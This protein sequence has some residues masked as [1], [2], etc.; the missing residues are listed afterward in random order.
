MTWIRS[1][2]GHSLTSGGVPPAWVPT[3]GTFANVGS[4]TLASV[5]PTGWPTSE[6]AGPY[7]NWSSGA[8][9]QDFG[10]IGGYVVHGS[11]HLTVGTPI[12][13]GVWVWDAS[14]TTW[15]GRNVPAAPLLEP[16]GTTGYDA[17]FASTDSTTL[18]H[19]YAPHTYDGLIYQSAANGGGAAGSLIRNFFAGSPNTNPRA[20]HKF[21]LSSAA[22]APSRVLDDVTMAGSSSSYPASALDEARGGYWL[23]TYNGQGPLKF[24]RFAD[25]SVTSYTGVEYSDYGD[26]HLIYLPAPYDAIVAIGRTDA[27]AIAQSLRVSQI[28]GGTPGTFVSI[29]PAGTAPAAAGSGKAGG[30]WSSLLSCIVQYTGDGSYTV[31][32]LTPPAP[33]SLTSG[34]WTWS[35]ETLTGVSGATPA[36]RGSDSSGSYSRFIEV[37]AFRCFLWSDGINNVMQAWR[38]T[39][40]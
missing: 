22:G 30:C 9:A 19:T 29:T 14:I 5:S 13:A 12:W 16:S 20:V 21:D 10:T 32:K 27:G 25:W 33:G 35:S 39:G 37:S 24:V 8:W 11:G 7:A 26:Q 6:D 18:G 4:S 23:L 28:T 15:V 31:F 1:S 3:A 17:F 40:M 34:T 36:T 2:G 38:L